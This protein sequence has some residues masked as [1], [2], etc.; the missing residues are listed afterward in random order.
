M[1][2]LIMSDDVP[3]EEVKKGN[4]AGYTCV[5]T[6]DSF[7]NAEK[8]S[9]VGDDSQVLTIALGGGDKLT[10]EPGCMMHMSEGIDINTKC[11]P[12]GC[13]RCCC[14]RSS[15]C[16]SEYSSNG[17]FVGLSPNFPSKVVAEHLTGDKHWVV[18]KSGFM[19]SLGDV[20]VDL[21]LDC[22]SATCCC[23]H[24]GYAR[25]GIHGDGTM[26]VNA[27]G[28][29]MRKELA[30]G[31]EILIDAGSI[32]AFEKSV[33]YDLKCIG[34]CMMICCGGDGLCAAKMTGPGTVYMQSMSFE[35]FVNVLST[36]PGMQ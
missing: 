26:F 7:G 30:E 9:I 34:N 29:L 28:T 14:L 24:M 36:P 12:N 8:V 16:I 13:T 22:C 35:K 2:E 5:S 6:E 31:E 27:G 1:G 18:K 20:N 10:A 21:D 3:L 15:C 19:A 33:N 17:G 23:G 25:Q 11:A 4:E 32:V